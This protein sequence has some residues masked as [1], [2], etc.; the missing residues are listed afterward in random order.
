MHAGHAAEHIDITTITMVIVT[1]YGWVTAMQRVM[2]SQ[3]YRING[4]QL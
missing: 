3:R 1:I 4:W 2:T